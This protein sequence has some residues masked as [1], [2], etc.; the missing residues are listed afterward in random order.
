MKLKNLVLPGL[1]TIGSLF[2]ELYSKQDYTKY[3]SFE[4][5]PIESI[6]LGDFRLNREEFFQIAPILYN[7]FSGHRTERDRRPEFPRLRNGLTNMIERSFN[8]NFGS[9]T[10]F[11][12]RP[13]RN[14]GWSRF[15]RR[16]RI[17]GTRDEEKRNI[18]RLI[19][20]SNNEYVEPSTNLIR[21]IG[22]ITN[23][24]H[25]AYSN[26]IARVVKGEEIFETLVP[27]G[28]GVDYVIA[29]NVLYSLIEN[30]ATN[31]GNGLKGKAIIKNAEGSDFKDLKEITIY[32]P[33]EG[34]RYISNGEITN[35]PPGQKY[36]RKDPIN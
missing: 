12:S 10:N 34:N 4:P 35:I 32:R 13:R 5:I 9:E 27:L 30:T 7:T 28:E 19:E 22:G 26:I 25:T 15:S 14:W 36:E 29:G 24:Y 17:R 16:G 1:I 8:L 11:P 18:T 31:S 33:G 23:V 3:Q 21:E 6:V 2:L 20:I